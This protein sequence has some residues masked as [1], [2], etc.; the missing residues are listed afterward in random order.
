MLNEKVMQ[1]PLR[2]PVTDKRAQLLNDEAAHLWCFTFDVEEIGAV[3]SDE[4]I[5][6]RNN[7]AAVGG[8]GKHLL[9]ASHGCIE[10]DLAR[11]RPRRTKRLA[12]KN[13]SIF[14]CQ[15]CIHTRMIDAR[16]PCSNG[17]GR[18]L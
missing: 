6:H 17:N 9:V 2:A 8:I 13:G 7:L 4:G 16:T 12:A 1:I 5:G 15:H 3:I 11:L 10:A 18:K 14:K